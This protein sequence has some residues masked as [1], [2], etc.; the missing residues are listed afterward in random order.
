[1]TGNTFAKMMEWISSFIAD[2][3]A[4]FKKLGEVFSVA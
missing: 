4:L 3:V 1:M 2:I